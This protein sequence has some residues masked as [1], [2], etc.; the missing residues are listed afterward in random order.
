MVL[1]FFFK[2]KTAYEMRISDWSSD[3]CSSDLTLTKGQPELTDLI[4]A[5]G[6]DGGEVLALVASVE[7][8]SEHPIAEAIVLAAKRD[9]LSVKAPEGFEAIP[10]FGVKAS[11][12]E[13]LVEV[14]A[15]RLMTRYGIDITRFADE[16]A[17][18][19]DEG[20]SPLYAVV[21]GRLAAVLAVADPIK[22]TTAEAL[23]ALPA[24]GV[25]DWEGQPSEP[26]Y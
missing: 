4:V 9:G 23:K 22:A 6:F 12:G 24:P 5:E 16:A 8:Q 17:R 25:M 20:K 26:Q 7:A 1:F 13:H 18:L 15:D 19:A 11:V 2:Q 21:D 10:G 3:V 14:G